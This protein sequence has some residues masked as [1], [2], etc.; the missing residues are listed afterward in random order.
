[1][2]AEA[3]PVL[4]KIRCLVCQAPVVLFENKNQLAYYGCANC[5]CQVM[6]RGVS[7]DSKLRAQLA[8]APPATPPKPAPAKES[9]SE[10]PKPVTA[11]PAKRAGIFGRA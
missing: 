5:G 11:A 9:P 1:M 2:S 4:G 3:K 10:K 8:P 7:A 6:T